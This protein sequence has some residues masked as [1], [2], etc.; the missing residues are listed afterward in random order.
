MLLGHLLKT[1]ANLEA[2]AMT[3]TTAVVSETRPAAAAVAMTTLMT[4]LSLIPMM[5]HSSF[6]QRG[7]TAHRVS[8]LNPL[9]VVLERA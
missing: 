4:S 1:R 7:C 3:A 8:F 9:G 5:K 6:L 2:R